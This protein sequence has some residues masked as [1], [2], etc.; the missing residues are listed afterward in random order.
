MKRSPSPSPSLGLA[1]SLILTPLQAFAA[2]PPKGSEDAQLMAGFESWF[3][4]Q[5]SDLSGW[6]CDISDGRPLAESELRRQG[7][8]LSVFVSKHHWDSAPEPGRWY[9][10]PTG[11]IIHKPNPVGVPIAWFYAGRIWCF[12]DGNQG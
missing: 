4:S 5:S 7:N 2:P 9:P 1:L 10:V 3:T 6:C 12:I 11:A 8:T